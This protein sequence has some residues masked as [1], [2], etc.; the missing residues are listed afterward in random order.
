MITIQLPNGRQYEFRHVVFDYNGVLAENGRVSEKVRQLLAV[1]A[2]KISVTVITADTFGTAQEEL[3]DVAGIELV[4]LP[5][6]K[7][8]TEKAYYVQKLGTETTAV[9]G[10]GVNDQPMFFIAGLKVCV[11]GA[12]G[13]SSG[14]MAG[15]DIV[16]RSPEDAIYLFLNPVRLSATLRS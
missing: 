12:E 10:N 9:V 5:E 3:K 13:V 7:D 1:L 11:L 14:I 16:V 4:I 15:A 8:G 2:S 6:D